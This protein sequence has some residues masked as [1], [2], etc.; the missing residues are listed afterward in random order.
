MPDALLSIA[1]A[2]ERRVD[3]ASHTNKSKH[4]CSATSSS[5]AVNELPL[6]S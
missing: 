5:L 6:D 3:N 1:S 2:P 4:A